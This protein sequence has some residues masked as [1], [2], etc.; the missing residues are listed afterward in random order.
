MS[1]D[2]PGSAGP[3]ADRLTFLSETLLDLHTMLDELV[4]EGF[5]SQRQAEDILIAPRTKKEL[6]QHPMEIVADRC[7]ENRKQPGRELDLDTMTLW[8]AEKSGQ[9]YERIDPLKGFQ[10]MFSL[11]SL[12]ELLKSMVKVA[13]LSAIALLVSKTLYADIIGLGR[14]G[15]AIAQRMAGEGRAVTGWTRSGRAVPGIA[16]APDLTALAAA[17]DVL[18]LS[19]FDD[20]A[21]A[22]LEQMAGGHLAA[23]AIVDRQVVQAAAREVVIHQQEGIGL[24]FKVLEIGVGLGG[25]DEQHAVGAPARRPEVLRSEAISSAVQ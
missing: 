21:V 18:V 19:L 16:T 3:L 22:E 8:L 5:I 14:M 9:P 12:L 20:A 6:S 17:S 1:A 15:A 24:L 11:Q 4:K 25:G 10:R 13:W 2:D 7:Y 23:L